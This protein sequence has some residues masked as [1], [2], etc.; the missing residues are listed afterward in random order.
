M[1]K[2]VGLLEKRFLGDEGIVRIKADEAAQNFEEQVSLIELN[3]GNP[4]EELKNL[5]MDNIR[6]FQELTYELQKEVVS[7]CDAVL[8]EIIDKNTIPFESLKP[9][10]TDEIFDEIYANTKE[11]STE[12]QAY[13]DGITFTHTRYRSVYSRQIHFDTLKNDIQSRLENIKNDLV[14]NVESFIEKITE[15]YINELSKNSKL[16]KYELD[17]IMEAKETAEQRVRIIEKLKEI[18]NFIVDE[19]SEI[20]KIKGGIKNNVH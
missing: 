12:K 3:S 8:V 4:F 20:T 19:K 7:G 10:F 18:K 1:R 2:G 14:E 16:K 17:S 5:S 9:D 13:E 6:Y 11:K 15:H